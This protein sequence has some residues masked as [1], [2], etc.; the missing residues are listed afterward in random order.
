MDFPQRYQAEALKAIE[1]IDLE[2]VEQAIHLLAEARDHER[3]VFVC[4]N[5]GSFST[6]AHFVTDLVKGASYGRASRFRAMALGESLSTV[7]AYSNDVSYECLLTE[8]LK[9]FARP[10]DVVIAFSGSGNSPNVVE[11]LRY[12]NSIGCRT[13]AFTGRDGGRLGPLAEIHIHIANPHMGRIEDAHM[14]AMHMIVYY[15][16]EQEPADRERG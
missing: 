8:E 13:V 5:G 1:C 3:Q 11:V 9:N 7:T 14:V 15:F 2:K 6:A 16:M 12:A 4:G 10:G